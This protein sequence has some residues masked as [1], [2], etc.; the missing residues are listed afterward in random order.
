MSQASYLLLAVLLLPLIGAVLVMFVPEGERDLARG[1][2]LGVTILTFLVSLA[3]LGPFDGRISGFQMVFDKEWIPGLGAHFKIGVDGISIWLVLLTTFLTP[4]VLLSAHRAIEDKVREFVAAMLVL[5]VAMVGTFLALDL[6]LFYVSWE[7]MLIPM[8]LLIGIWGGQR[9]VYASI[10]FVIYTMVGSLLMLATI[11]Y[12][13]SKY[14]GVTGEF[15]TDLEKLDDLVLPQTAQ[16]WCFAAFALAFAI[17]VPLFPLHTW[18]PDAHVEAPTAGSVVLAG[19]LLKFGI[20]GFLRFAM[21]LFPYGAAA[22][23]PVIGIIAV[24]GIVYGALVAFVQDDVKKLVAYSSVSH[25]GFCMLGLV[26]LTPQAIEGA[27]FGML[28]HGLTTGGLFLAIGVLYERRHTRRM[29]DFGG[30]WAPMPV[31]G[32]LFL[33]CVLGSAG[34]PGTSGFIGEFLTIIGTFI[35]GPD[36]FPQGWATFLPIPKILAAG[37]ATGVI[38]GAVYLLYMFQ[39]VMFGPIRDEK[40]RHLPDVSPR[41]IAVFVPIV[42]GIFLMGIFPRPFLKMTEPAVERFIREF[43]AKLSEP[44]AAPHLAGKPPPG[45]TPVPAA[46]PGAA[47]TENGAAP[48]APGATAPTAPGATAPAPGTPAPAPGAAPAPPPA[49]APPV[50]PAPGGSAQPAPAPA[51]AP[52]PGAPPPEPS[53][54]SGAPGGQP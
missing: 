19:V 6:F 44:D 36:T 16:I 49:P 42:L 15:T 2:G 28:S 23:A 50:A 18:L 37:A 13:Y 22:A 43:K 26:A 41:E 40:N 3:I 29:A 14:S 38:L 7:L 34:L 20:Y 11:F 9:R 27:I 54:A 45:D 25:L 30:V 24:A 47:P 5:E 35:A 21:P 51:A 8:Y 48:T 17:K 53:P 33:I 1:I 31:F 12:V 4:I 10:K 32:A 46:N 39:K 52:T